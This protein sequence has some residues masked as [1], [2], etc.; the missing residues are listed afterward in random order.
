MHPAICGEDLFA[1]DG[2]TFAVE[3]RHFSPGFQ[4]QQATRRLVPGFQVEFPEPFEPAYRRVTQIQRGGTH[5]PYGLALLDEITEMVEVVVIG[6][7]DVIGESG[8]EQALFQIID[9]RNQDGF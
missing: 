2:E 9:G 3:P 7:F 1:F 5:P 6:L 8:N 4:D